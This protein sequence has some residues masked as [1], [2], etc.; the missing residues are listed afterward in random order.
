MESIKRSA[1]GPI[2]SVMLRGTVTLDPEA[3]GVEQARLGR[4][5]GSGD[6]F[7]GGEGEE[8]SGV[9]G[10][11]EE[12]VGSF[13]VSCASRF[14]RRSNFF[15]TD[16]WV[17]TSRVEEIVFVQWL[18]RKSR[19]SSWIREEKT[20]SFTWIA[21]REEQVVLKVS[22]FLRKVGDWRRFSGVLSRAL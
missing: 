10:S 6:V 5:S 2:S 7:G 15:S 1:Q 21:K 16:F 14:F 17:S 3:R 9:T 12:P 11:C 18:R 8:D 20:R 22:S 13:G 4:N 19:S